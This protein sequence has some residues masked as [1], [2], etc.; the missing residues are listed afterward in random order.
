MTGQ[1]LLPLAGGP[2]LEFHVGIVGVSHNGHFPF[3]PRLEPGGAAVVGHGSSSF[4]ASFDQDSLGRDV[5]GLVV[6]VFLEERGGLLVFAKN[7]GG[8]VAGKPGVEAG[9]GGGDALLDAGGA[10]GVGLGEGSEAFAEACGVFVRDGENSDAALGAAGAA[11]EVRAAAKSGGGES[12][13]DNLDQVVRRGLADF[14]LS[15][16]VPTPRVYT[17]ICS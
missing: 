5:A 11:D 7:A 8:G 6:G 2:V 15:P 17:T 3:D 1:P 16:V 4:V 10:V 9:E 12:S 13:G 14:C